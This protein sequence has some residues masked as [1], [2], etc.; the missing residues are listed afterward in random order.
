MKRI[1]AYTRENNNQRYR[2][3]R[4]VLVFF[5]IRLVLLDFKYLDMDF[6]YG[7]QEE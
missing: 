2:E 1:E 5:K 4:D 3:E 6:G 7:S